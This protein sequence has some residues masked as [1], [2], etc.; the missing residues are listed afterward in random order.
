MWPKPLNSTTLQTPKNATKKTRIPQPTSPHKFH[1]IAVLDLVAEVADINTVF[2]L[3]NLGEFDGFFMLCVD[4]STQGASE[5]LRCL[6]VS[7]TRVRPSGTRARTR[8][9][10]ATA[11][12]RSRTPPRPR[13]RA[14]ASATLEQ[15]EYGLQR[16]L[17]KNKKTYVTSPLWLP[18]V[19]PPRTGSSLGE[20]STAITKTERSL[21]NPIPAYHGPCL[22]RDPFSPYHGQCRGLGH[23]E[24]VHDRS[25]Y[26]YHLALLYSCPRHHLCFSCRYPFC[27]NRKGCVTRVEQER[28]DSQIWNIKIFSNSAQIRPQGQ[29]TQ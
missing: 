5:G 28:S 1:K 26:H 15:H 27:K 20:Q 3:A 16:R 13:T 2:T 14:G 10:T 23:P 18:V 6:P 29:K 8:T 22:C 11:T 24:P 4:W 25:P 12:G 21:A 9:R 19:I 17:R 7:A